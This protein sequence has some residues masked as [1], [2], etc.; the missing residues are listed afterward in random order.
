MLHLPRTQPTKKHLLRRIDAT[1]AKIKKWDQTKKR[2]GPQRGRKKWSKFLTQFVGY[3]AILV[4]D[5]FLHHVVVRNAIARGGGQELGRT[6]K[7]QKA[8]G[9]N[10]ESTPHR[11]S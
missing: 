2:N 11:G 5:E 10:L 6:E 4:P 8:Q 7:V 9:A 1:I 3:L